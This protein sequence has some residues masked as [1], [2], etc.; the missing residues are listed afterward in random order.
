MSQR[1]LLA[2]GGG[3]SVFQEGL[4]LPEYPP[5]PEGVSAFQAE[6]E[7]GVINQSSETSYRPAVLVSV[8]LP[9][10]IP[11]S[12]FFFDRGIAEPLAPRDNE[13]N[14]STEYGNAAAGG[15]VEHDTR[16]APQGP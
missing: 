6:V 10:P 7:S 12:N 4:G 2:F 1:S 11:V 5:P 13:F 8:K 3:L 14:F 9:N 15:I 16:R